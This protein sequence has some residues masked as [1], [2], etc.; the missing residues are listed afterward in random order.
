MAATS[1]PTRPRRV[2][3]RFSLRT[4]LLLV[5]IACLWLGWVVNRARTQR[6]AVDAIQSA[7]GTIRFDYHENGPRSWSTAGRPRGPQWLRSRLGSEYFDHPVY[8]G[9]FNTPQS[10]EWIAAFNQLPPIK[11]LLLSGRHVNDET[12]A[13]LTGSTTLLELSL[14][15]SS[16][17]DKGLE[18][19]AK[20]PNL[21]WLVLNHTTITDAGAT[22]LSELQNL[23]ELNL[24]GTAISV[25]GVQEIQK[26]LPSANVMH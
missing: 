18:H 12:L 25:D 26:S 21:R 1:S 2:R 7:G 17:S 20:F 13:Q 23:Q 6:A 22:F 19:L 14:S 9:L 15:N 24:R 11:S 16:I 4:V 5:T 10:Q 3:L 8:V